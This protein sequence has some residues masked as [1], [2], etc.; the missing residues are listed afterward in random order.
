MEVDTL[1]QEVRLESVR[2]DS[3]HGGVIHGRGRISIAPDAE[4][5]P[6]AIDVY[7]EGAGLP[8]KELL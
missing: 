7:L 1:A 4:L 6:N 3:V 2:I 5:N 8:V